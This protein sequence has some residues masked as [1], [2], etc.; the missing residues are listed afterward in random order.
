MGAKSLNLR[1]LQAT[2]LS[3]CF[4]HCQLRKSSGMEKH[5]EAGYVDESGAGGKLRF[6][7]QRCGVLDVEEEAGLGSWAFQGGRLFLK[8]TMLLPRD[9]L[10]HDSHARPAPGNGSHLLRC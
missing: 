5:V 1:Q 9:L 2:A 7:R 6:T 3:R 4:C 8:S 10:E